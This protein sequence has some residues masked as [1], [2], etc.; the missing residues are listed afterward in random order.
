[1]PVQ[2]TV[3]LIGS[4][5]AA[6]ASS[7]L[8]DYEGIASAKLRRLSR[9]GIGAVALLVLGFG[10]L[11]ALLPMAGAVIAPGSITVETHVKQVAHPFGGVVSQIFVGD[12]DRVRKGQV[13][14]RLDSTVS[15]AAARYTGL[16]LTQLLARAARLRALRDETPDLRPPAEFNGRHNNAEV[17][18]AME[19]ERH[20]L[21]LARRARAD[22]AAQL[23]ARIAQAQAQIARYSSQS[24]AYDR[25]SRLIAEELDQTRELYKERFTTLDRLNALERAAAGLD[26]NKDTALSSVTEARALI[27]D[28][29]AQLAALASR[30]RSAAAIELVTV[31][32]LVAE[33][34]RQGITAGDTNARAAIRSP[35]DGVVDKLIVRTVG[36]VVPPG[37]TLLEVVPDAD[38]LT[39]EAHVR[40]TD[41]D[42]VSAGRPATLRLVAFSTRTTPELQGTVT[43]VDPDR[44]IDAARGETFYRATIALP[45]AEIAKLEGLRL[46]VGMPVE[47][48]IRSGQRTI[49]SY[50]I[51]PLRD[52]LARAL[53]E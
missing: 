44:T 20:S 39:V 7:W 4:P 8:T 2:D 16:N 31:E 51:R 35:Q 52:Q 15:N 10:G 53:R 1:M 17:R 42:Q 46:K 26:A 22:Q 32:N 11:A 40:T 49:L 19:D 47:V 37:Q 23:R 18:A 33:A 43:H 24:G 36:G 41:I 21:V 3:R 28:F 29:G 30:E 6:R 27:V 25:Q 13:L 38:R 12:G 48:Y 14:I 9:I 5:A 50:I 34:R 45:K